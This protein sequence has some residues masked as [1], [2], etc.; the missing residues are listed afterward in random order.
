MLSSPNKIQSWSP[1]EHRWGSRRS[2]CASEVRFQRDTSK[3]TDAPMLQHDWP[4]M[5]AWSMERILKLVFWLEKMQMDRWC[6]RLTLGV[7]AF[8]SHWL[9]RSWVSKRHRETR[10]TSSAVRIGLRILR[11]SMFNKVGRVSTIKPE[12]IKHLFP[13]SVHSYMDTR[14]KRI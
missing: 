13:T 5:T 9:I 14:R 2:R 7:P 6:Q 12:G 11:R 8:Q 10:R 1:H 4:C 3:L